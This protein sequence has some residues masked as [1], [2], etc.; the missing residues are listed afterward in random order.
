[1]NDMA[2]TIVLYAL[3]IGMIVGVFK[4]YK[5]HE[6]AEIDRG[7]SSMFSSYPPGTYKLDTTIVSCA[8]LKA[9]DGVAYHP[10]TAP[11]TL[12]VARVVA[13]EGDRVQID[14]ASVR[15]NGTVVPGVTDRTD[16]QIPSLEIPRGCVFLLAERSGSAQDS[17]VT[18]PVPMAQIAWRLK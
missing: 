18:G 15:V 4:L 5:N 8:G 12:R 2:R 17:L 13:R 1:M 7:D 3:L 11:G 14:G 6:Q 9:G 10:S 16:V